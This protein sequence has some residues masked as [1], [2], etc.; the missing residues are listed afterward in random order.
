MKRILA[1]LISF[2]IMLSLC[3]C[4]APAG[5]GE[6][7]AASSAAEKQEELVSS[8]EAPG[9]DSKEAVLSHGKINRDLN[10]GVVID[11]EVTGLSQESLSIYTGSVRVFTA[12]EVAKALGLSPKDALSSQTNYS[13][14]NLIPGDMVY[15]EFD[16]SK[17]LICDMNRFYYTTDTFLNLRDLLITDG[18]RK[19]SNAFSTDKNLDF[20]TVEQ[21]QA[22][23]QLILD[24]LKIPVLNEP[25][26]YALDFESLSSENERLYALAV[27]EAK[28]FD[29]GAFSPERITITE[30]EACY[31][32]Y[33]PIA[34][35]GL[36]VSSR[37]SG[38]YGDGSLMQ[39]TE[40]V[41][42][43]SKA[44]IIGLSLEYQP[45]V[46]EKSEAKPIIPLEEMLD[47]IEAKYDSLILDG[48][49]LIYD[50]RLEY[51]AKPIFEEEN[52]YTL[53]PVWRFSIEHSFNLDK[54]D[55]TD[56]SQQATDFIYNIFDAITGQELPMDLG[57]A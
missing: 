24:K 55:G 36:P 30:D 13:L 43:Y 51:I 41:V 27:E 4:A 34:V 18:S 45:E 39:G 1:A 37:M 12:D 28:E 29:T 52:R 32:F 9:P 57:G 49:Y 8:S 33:Y 5:K 46:I 2:S 48:E 31:M 15:M 54:G 16:D 40:L 21:A 11:A 56:A 7:S 14:D 19:N 26:C 53:V 3:S 22:E 47:I 25:T 42:C 6:V 10:S 20:A 17:K 44:G 50:I 23:I 38:V 35:D